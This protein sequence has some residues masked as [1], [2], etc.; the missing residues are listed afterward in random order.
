MT[1]FNRNFSILFSGAFVKGLGSGIYAV[2]AMLLVL[3]LTGNVFYSGLT[4]FVISIPN[5]LG[6]LIAPLANY[7][8]YKVSMIVAEFMKSALLVSIPILY[9]F[10]LLHVFYVIGIMFLTA[11]ISQFTYPIESTLIPSFVGGK[12]VV[13]ANS[14]MQTLRE[15]MDIVFLAIAGL[16]I[17][18]IGNAEAVLITA[19]CHF[20]TGILYMFFRMESNLH[21]QEDAEVKSGIRSYKE[22]LKEGFTYISGSSLFKKMLG[23]VIVINFFFGGMLAVLPAFTLEIGGGDQ[24]YGYFLSA[25][26]VGSL[27]GA[28]VTPKLNQIP[29]GKLYVYGFML[30]GLSVMT[31]SFVPFWVGLLLIMM[32]MIAVTV[33]NILLFSI[34]QQKVKLTLVGRVITV[35]SSLAGVATPLGNLFGGA[36]GSIDVK[37]PIILAGMAIFLFSIYFLVQ[38]HLR[39]IP[40]SDLVSFNPKYEITA[41]VLEKNAVSE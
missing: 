4:F 38:P 24:H 33:T 3:H 36:V 7:I 23:P 16:L 6:F 35:I 15:G 20:I 30:A 1:L 27:L 32:T 37:Y 31:I 28:V 11:L 8:P 13:K 26:T 9:F 14:L 2:A 34:I 39:T 10:E 29:L 5:I 17:A 22:D 18:F 25:I 40:R 21:K 19:A 12:N 41:D